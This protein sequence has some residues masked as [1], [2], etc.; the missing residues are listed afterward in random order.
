MP[1]QFITNDSRRRIIEAYLNGQTAYEIA[2]IM[3]FKR[4]SVYAIINLHK[5]TGNF[6]R[7]LKEGPNRNALTPEDKREIINWVDEDCGV[8][9]RKIKEKLQR[10]RNV[11]VSKSTIERCIENFKYSFK[12]VHNISIRRNNAQSLDDRV[13]YANMFMN[14]ISTNGR[15]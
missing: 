5:E 14:F 13:I 1:N 6:E 15:C 11:I 9:L 3:G 2:E 12:R 7:R 4:T 8:S 10:E